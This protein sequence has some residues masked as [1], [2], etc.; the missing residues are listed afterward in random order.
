MLASF[1]VSPRQGHIDQVFHIFGYLKAK[2]NCE[3]IFDPTEPDINESDF[4]KED[5]SCSVYNGV[6]EILPPNAPELRGNGFI[7]RAYVDADHVCQVAEICMKRK[8]CTYPCRGLKDFNALSPGRG[9]Q[10]TQIH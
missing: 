8:S 1:M 4:P 7:I 10:S 2:H 6:K 9:P 3:M 5:W